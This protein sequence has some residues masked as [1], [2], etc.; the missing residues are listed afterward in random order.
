VLEPSFINSVTDGDGAAS[1]GTNAIDVLVPAFV[2]TFVFDAPVRAFSLDVIGA[3][4]LGGDLFYSVDNRE[5]VLFSGPLPDGHV[6]FLG[7]IDLMT[8]F[9]EVFFF[10]S[11]FIDVFMM[12]RVRY[13]APASPQPVPEPASLTLLA[14]GLAAGAV[15]R[16]RRGRA[17]A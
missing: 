1:D 10:S 8:P 7:F 14:A 13:E 5:D 4:D 12:D 16:Y 3:L 9:T 11:E 6:Q 15:R 2:P 17:H